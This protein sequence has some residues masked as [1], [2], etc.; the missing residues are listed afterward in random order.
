MLFDC[1][2]LLGEHM[3]QQMVHGFD[4]ALDTMA[5]D[6]KAAGGTQVADLAKVFALADIGNVDFYCWYCYRF[7]SVQQSHGSMGVSSWVDDNAIHGT[8][9]R[10]NLVDKIAFVVALVDVYLDAALGGMGLNQLTEIAVCG[11]AINVWFADA[12]HI[13][14]WAVN[15]A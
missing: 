14:I 7:E 13:K 8:I 1:V 12:Q 11:A 5:A 3:I 15:N 10:L 2:E 4:V 9:A 6:G